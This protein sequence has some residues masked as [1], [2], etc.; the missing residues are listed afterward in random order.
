[1]TLTLMDVTDTIPL[2]TD[3]HGSIRIGKSRITLDT[4]IETYK[5]GATIEELAQNFPTLAVADI[6]YTVGYYLRH[7]EEVETYLAEQESEA[8]V[9]RKKIESD[10]QNIEFRARLKG[11]IEKQRGEI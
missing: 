11:R 6:M 7:T 3:E 1:M 5:M 2:H 8:E 10:P 4:I 9:I